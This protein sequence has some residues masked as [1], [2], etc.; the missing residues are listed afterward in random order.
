MELMCSLQICRLKKAYENST[1]RNLK[2]PLS[3]IV[4]A[5]IAPKVMSMYTW[6]GKANKLAFKPFLEVQ[7]VLFRTVR[8][9]NQNYSLPKLKK[10]L[11]Y[12]VI[13]YAYKYANSDC[14]GNISDSIASCCDTTFVLE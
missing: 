6:T 1:I 7:N 5:L 11:I 13:E 3:T 10:E 4:N 9:I 12:N 8:E 2:H 14:N